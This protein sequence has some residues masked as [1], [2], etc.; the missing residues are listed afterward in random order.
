MIRQAKHSDLKRIQEMGSEFWV[1]SN[2]KDFLGELDPEGLHRFYVHLIGKNCLMVADVDGEVV[3]MMG[4]SIFQHPMSPGKKIAQEHFWWIEPE[5][6]RSGVG[7]ELLAT[8]EH[9][10]KA[11][12][13]IGN[14]MI[15]L[16]GVDH[17]RV[18]NFYEG[19]GYRP[20]EYVYFKGFK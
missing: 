7:S 8:A 17:E 10:I 16:H 13:A 4:F 15:T 9:L 3:G 20:F 12:G 5:H 19:E 6:R 18:G 2:F 1:E 14:F 11:R